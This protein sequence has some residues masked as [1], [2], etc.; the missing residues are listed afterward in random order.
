MTYPRML[1]VAFVST[2]FLL[3]SI[4]SAT[5]LDPALSIVGSIPGNIQTPEVGDTYSESLYST[6]GGVTSGSPVTNV[7][8]TDTG[9]G[10][11]HTASLS[12]DSA[13]TDIFYS[14]Y[15]IT[16]SNSS[17]DTYELTF[18]ITYDHT[19]DADA[20]DLDARAISRLDVGLAAGTT[21]EYLDLE[22]ESESG[23]DYALT[24]PTWQDRVDTVYQ[25]TNGALLN[26]AD[27]TFFTIQLVGVSS[28]DL[29]AEYILSGRTFD[30]GASFDISSNMYIFLESFENLT[31]PVPEPS[32]LILL[33]AGLLGLLCH[34]HRRRR[35]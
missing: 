22:L 21:T 15:D 33:I 3:P 1:I 16:T 12:G 20:G 19:S 32:S 31:N 4:A 11:G 9:D 13:A 2:G 23:D 10:Y 18:G 30:A 35:V 6:V 28:L 34:G 17:T 26:A 5:P 29:E 27:T 14:N 24:H 8:L 7:S 25:G